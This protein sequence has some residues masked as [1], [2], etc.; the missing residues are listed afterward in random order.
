MKVFK[1]IRKGASKAI[2]ALTKVFGV[3]AKLYYPLESNSKLHGFIDNDIVYREEPE[4]IRAL[5]PA[6]F[7]TGNQVLAA[8]DPFHDDGERL[9]YAPDYVSYPRFSKLVLLYEGTTLTFLIN[10][11]LEKK[12]DETGEVI[13]RKYVVVPDLTFSAADNLEGLA[14]TLEDELAEHEFPEDDFVSTPIVP[15]KNDDIEHT[16]EIEPIKIIRS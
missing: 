3:D 14:A 2:E 9:L 7:R 4:D 6:L 5:I 15:A 13:M 8:L 11:V 16:L 1:G 12:D 10:E